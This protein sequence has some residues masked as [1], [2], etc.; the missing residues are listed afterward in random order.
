M[1]MA[2]L[3]VLVAW[4]EIEPFAFLKESYARFK[5]TQPLEL[6]NGAH[7]IYQTT[8]NPN[9]TFEV[10]AGAHFWFPQITL[11][12]ED[13][14]GRFIQTLLVTH[15]TAKGEFIGGRTKDNFKTFDTEKGKE[16]AYEQLRRVDALPHWSHARGVRASDGLFA[17]MAS[18]PLPDGISGATPSGSFQLQTQHFETTKF[19]VL[20]EVNVAF[21]DNKYYSEYDFPDNTAYHSGTG[22]LGQPSIVYEAVIDPAKPQKYYL[23][24]YKGHTSPSGPGGQLYADQYGLT[25]A[26]QIIDL[27]LIKCQIK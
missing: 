6:E 19:K 21:D 25:T 10:R 9:L 8:E 22:L 5:A 14:T 20:L 24:K 26:L 11:W 4:F 3:I 17:P 18:D 7:V 15:S 16:M 12:T 13:T 1:L 2:T 27:A 23:M